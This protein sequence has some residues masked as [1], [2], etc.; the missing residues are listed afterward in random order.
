MMVLVVEGRI[1]YLAAEPQDGLVL[2]RRLEQ[3]FSLRFGELP[4]M[5]LDFVQV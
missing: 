4:F 1:L 3:V 2:P 5:V